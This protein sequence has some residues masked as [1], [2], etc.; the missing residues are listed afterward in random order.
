MPHSD[1]CYIARK[2]GSS[3]SF[4]IILGFFEGAGGGGVTNRGVAKGHVWF[5]R[6]KF[7]IEL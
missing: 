1:V 2:R 4:K 7:E 5:E 6:K 3:Q